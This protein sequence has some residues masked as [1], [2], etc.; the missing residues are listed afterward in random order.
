VPQNLFPVFDIPDALAETEPQTQRYRPAPL[1]DIESGDFVFNGSRQALYGTGYDAWVLWCI[2][3]I[4]TQRWAH[5]GYSGNSGVETEQA[6][7]EPDRQAQESA[8]E[9][10][11]SEALLADPMGRTRQVRDFDFKWYADSLT[12]SCDVVGHDGNSAA[13]STSINR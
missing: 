10:T 2:K 11:I 6:F 7:D 12:V 8:F 5:L 9:R 3:T 1:W 4:H 13:I